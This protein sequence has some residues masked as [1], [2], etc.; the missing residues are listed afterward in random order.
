[1]AIVVPPP[2]FPQGR[3][4]RRSLRTGA[5]VRGRSPNAAG[6]RDE[7][8]VFEAIPVALR[9]FARADG[10]SPK[11]TTIST[12]FS[13]FARFLRRS[14]GTHGG[15]PD[16]ATNAEAAATIRR[17]LRRCGH[18]LRQ[19][20]GFCDDFRPFSRKMDPILRRSAELYGETPRFPTMR[21][22]FFV[23]LGGFPPR[24]PDRRDVAAI[25]GTTRRHS[26][27]RGGIRHDAAPFGTTPR[28]SA[29]RRVPRGCA[30]KIR[31]RHRRAEFAVARRAA[32][33]VRD[34]T[35]G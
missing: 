31:N 28:I 32:G 19:S 4:W 2:Y 20:A 26:A 17:A 11:N 10:V 3:G 14:G 6:A 34:A 5:E 25:L 18:A 9:R 8:P 33:P 13:D 24:R 21:R 1:L 16:V 15:A 27:R 12:R 7:A 23:K 30:E 29:R 22:R 35:T